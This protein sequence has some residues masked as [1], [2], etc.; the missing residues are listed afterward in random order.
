MEKKMTQVIAVIGAQWGDEGKGKIVDFLSDGAD[1]CVRFQ[2]GSNAGHTIIFEGN[3]YKLRL[4]PSG[5]LRGACGIL[6]AGMAINLDVLKKEFDTLVQMIG[7]E[8]ASTRLMI[9]HR[10]HTILPIH[11]EVDSNR[12]EKS[13]NRIGT[14]RNGI[15]VCYEDKARRIGLRIGDLLDSSTWREKSNLIAKAHSG[16]DAA[17]TQ[18]KILSKLYEWRRDWIPFIYDNLSFKLHDIMNGGAEKVIIEGA[19]GTFLDISHG[20]YPFVTSST[21]IASGIGAAIGCALPRDTKIIGV[22]KAYCT[23]VGAGPFNLED[24]GEL[25]ERLRTK[26]GEFGVVTGRARRCGWNS[27]PMLKEAQI[28]N[29]FTSLAITKVDVLD[30]FNEVKIGLKKGFQTFDGWDNS[31]GVQDYAQLDN[32]L[33]TYIDFINENVAPVSIISTGADRKDTIFV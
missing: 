5:V 3:T 24:T 21:T 8:Q 6:G 31:A 7:Y 28:L 1:Y 9:D 29:G 33:K 19:Q 20:T 17:I 18:D 10:A 2:G 12:E 27:L 25:G 30:G 23:R 22:V 16:L 14:T 13:N 26:G 4:L 11:I 15:G 32:N